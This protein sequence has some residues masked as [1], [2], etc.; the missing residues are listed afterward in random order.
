MHRL[1]VVK[2]SGIYQKE[3]E[4]CDDYLMSDSKNIHTWTYRHMIVETFDLWEGE[5]E[6]TDSMVVPPVSSRIY[7]NGCV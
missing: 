3:K 4:F 2:E 5:L 6:Y 7:S 1:F